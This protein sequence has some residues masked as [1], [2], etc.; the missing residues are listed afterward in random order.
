[1]R[2][3]ILG[4]GLVG[5]TGGVDFLRIVTDSLTRSDAYPRDLELHLLFPG[6]GPV[7]L[8]KACYRSVK[9]L[10]PGARAASG[11]AGLL[12]DLLA[13]F[14]SKVAFHE[15]DDGHYAAHR[16]ARRLGVDCLL[17]ALRPLGSHEPPWVGYAYDFQHRHL[18]H[19]FGPREKRARDRHFARMTRL[20]STI[21]VNSKAVADDLR[22]FYP[23]CTA[24]VVRMPF[25]PSPMPDWFE[26]LPGLS[27]KYGVEGRYFLISNHFWQHK[28]HSLAFEAFARLREARDL[29]LVCTGATHDFRDPAYMDRLRR[30]VDRLGIR[31]RV[32][33]LDVI[34]KRDQ[35][36]LMK[37]AVAVIQPT[38]F[39]GGPG[40]G[41]VYDAIAVGTPVILSDIPVNREVVGG[42]VVYFPPADAAALRHCLERALQR[43]PGRSRPSAATLL[44]EGLERRR[45]CGNVILGAATTAIR[46]ARRG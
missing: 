31:E 34:P 30:L 38:L 26:D 40:G 17:P 23:G 3:G 27:R 29:Q 32:R 45:A 16:T 36:E 11:P 15:C 12:P 19:L 21:L 44:A 6:R 39:E 18:E 24:S 41:A 42:D 46:L 20:A 35:I 28:N 22:A 10:L 4:H 2:L 13:E 8:L 33:I 43:E 14:H 37:G 7:A 25:A 1:M 5:W 9:G